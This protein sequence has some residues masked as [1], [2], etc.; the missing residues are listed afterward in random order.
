MKDLFSGHAAD[1]ALYRPG[2]PKALYD[3]VFERVTCFDAAWDCGTGNGQVA[4]V[5]AERFKQVEATDI[6]AA[7]MEQAPPA[8]NVHYLVCL[9]ETTPFSPASFDLVTVGQALHWFDFEQFNAE[10][11]RVAKPGALLAVWTYELVSI[12]PEIDTLIFDFYRNTLGTYWDKERKHVENRY[13]DIP[14]PY[15]NIEKKVFKQTYE[16]TLDQVCRYLHTWSSVRKFEKINRINPVSELQQRLALLWGDSERKTVT[17][18]VFTQ[19]G[20]I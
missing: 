7:Q 19:L 2:Y 11:K 5:L 8:Q 13:A 4:R 20:E 1:Y 10:V 17:F 3:W 16:W 14:F 18:P 6:S 9:A 12:S 15:G